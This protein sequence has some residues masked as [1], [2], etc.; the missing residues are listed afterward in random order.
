MAITQQP[1]GTLPPYAL[2]VWRRINGAT[3][4]QLAGYDADCD[5][6]H[7]DCT[8]IYREGREEIW[9]SLS[10]A[11][12]EISKVL[13]Y[14]PSHRDVTV[15]YPLLGNNHRTTYLDLPL[16][17]VR[18]YGKVTYAQEGSDAIVKYSK[19][20]DSL[21]YMDRA[22]FSI[23]TSENTDA[24][25]LR[26]LLT[27]CPDGWEQGTHLEIHPYRATKSG[28][29]VTF[30]LH[31][32][33]LTKP[34]IQEQE[35]QDNLDPQSQD[36]FVTK[37]AVY[38]RTIDTATPAELFKNDGS[39][40]D[41]VSVYSMDD[42]DGRFWLPIF[43]TGET[44]VTLKVY[45][46]MGYD[47]Q[48]GTMNEGLANALVKLA[49]THVNQYPQNLSG[50]PYLNMETDRERL[51]EVEFDDSLNIFGQMVGAV[52][53]ARIVKQYKSSVWGVA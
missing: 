21:E 13:G 25:S 26:F 8:P 48:F 37:V 34:S 22:S 38:K 44:N 36:N 43:N 28:S 10:T 18:E 32:A 39:L 15:K 24:L 7:T 52:A 31:P 3:H 30:Y 41:K 4:W 46:N 14:Y 42:E 17:R 12:S 49:N 33:S 45:V 51:E 50:T 23:T 35:Y 6:P 40:I 9:R 5:V 47:M 53:A 16:G 2:D 11:W 1:I 27:D 29:T 20:N 19:S